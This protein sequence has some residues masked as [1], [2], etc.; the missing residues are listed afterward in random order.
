MDALID[1]IDYV[2][3]RWWFTDVVFLSIC[4]AIVLAAALLT[5]STEAVSLFGMEVPV[6]C[7]WRQLTGMGCP[8]CGLTRSF[9]F[10]AHGRVVEAFRL[11]PLGPPMFLFVAVQ[12][13]WRVLRLVRRRPRRDAPPT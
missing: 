4:G 5:P 7:S 13:P 8:G 3:S 9:T 2:G 12:V 10:M 11:N 6:L 1:R